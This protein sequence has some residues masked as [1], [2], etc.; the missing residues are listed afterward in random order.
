MSLTKLPEGAS[1]GELTMETITIHSTKEQVAVT[2]ADYGLGTHTDGP[3]R[4]TAGKHL[5]KFAQAEDGRL[6]RLNRHGNWA[7][8]NHGPMLLR[9]EAAFATPKGQGLNR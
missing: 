2:V 8:V 1:Q 7:A 9:A 5:R 6:F 4:N 3:T